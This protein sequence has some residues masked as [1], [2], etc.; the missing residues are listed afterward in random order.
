MRKLIALIFLTLA[1]LTVAV[2]LSLRARGGWGSGGCSTDATVVAQATDGWRVFNGIRYLYRNGRQRAAFNPL[3]HIYRTYDP[4]TNTWGPEVAPPWE[5]DAAPTKVAQ[6]PKVVK[7]VPD[8]ICTP[9]HDCAK[10]GCPVDCKCSKQKPRPPAPPA[11]QPLTGVVWEK[12]KGGNRYTICGHEITKDLAHEALLE[13]GASEVPNDSGKIRLTLIGTDE[14]CKTAFSA[15]A[16]ANLTDNMVVQSY[17]PDDWAVRPGFVTAGHPS[18]YM[19]A[20]DGKVL[21]RQSAFDNTTVQAVRKAV[22]DYDPKKDPDGAPRVLPNVD[23]AK[24]APYWPLG[25]LGGVAL[26]LLLRKG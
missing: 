6:T 17:R 11:D 24:L 14:E 7:Q 13:S 10:D 18:I 4:D 12:V 25:L 3:T 15:L 16:K 20:P 19:Q 23:L 26:L 21:L 9:D 1:V 22:P 8:C 2:S 5:P